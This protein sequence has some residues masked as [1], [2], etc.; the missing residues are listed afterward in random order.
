MKILIAEDEPVIAKRIERLT[1]EILGDRITHIKKC[2]TLEE[3]NSYLLT[4]QID[5]LFLD[6]NL[7]GKDGFDVLKSAQSGAF[8]TVI[9]SAYS[10]QAIRA[11]DHPV[12][13]FVEKPFNKERLTRTFEKLSN[14][15]AKNNFASK[16]L[17]LKH[18]GEIKLVEVDRIIYLKGAGVYSELFLVDDKQELHHKNLEK[19]DRLLP[20]NF[21]RVHKSYIVNFYFV[22][23]LTSHGGSKYSLLL[24]TGQ[25]LPVS[26]TRYQELKDLLAAH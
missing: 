17:S 26:R 4:Q 16:F 23:S 11:F 1:R 7:R 22:Q 6:L 10:E 14:F 13:D 24:K 8:H 12:I 19:I 20:S 25:E 9:I 15:D 21:C 5:L 3:C 2:A 18:D